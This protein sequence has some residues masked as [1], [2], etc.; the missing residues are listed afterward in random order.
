MR[1]EHIQTLLRPTLHS[2]TRQ[3]RRN[4][5]DEDIDFVVAR[6]RYIYCAGALHIFLRR[7]DIPRHKDI[8][9]RFARLEGTVLVIN[10]QH[11][12]PVLITVYHN[13]DSF[14]QIRSK[15]KYDVCHRRSSHPYHYHGR[16]VVE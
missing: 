14:K 1:R 6:G 16:Y 7:R 3:A 9:D 11:A 15:A 5:S 2:L 4:L 12:I 8:N 10:I 13:R